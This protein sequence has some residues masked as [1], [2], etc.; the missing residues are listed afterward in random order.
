MY[1]VTLKKFKNWNAIEHGEPLIKLEDEYG[2]QSV[3]ALSD[4]CFVLYNGSDDR[5]FNPVNHWYPEAARA[6]SDFLI[7]NP[8]FRMDCW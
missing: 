6:L 2:G 8:R 1:K 4:R 7:C 3:I 5:N